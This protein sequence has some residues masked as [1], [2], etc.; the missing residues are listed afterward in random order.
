MLESLV[1]LLLLLSLVSAVPDMEFVAL[2]SAVLSSP[3]ANSNSEQGSPSRSER[4]DDR[5]IAQWFT[6]P[7]QGLG[8]SVQAGRAP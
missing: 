1:S 7:L 3:Q 2:P 4:V 5:N 6:H 8:N